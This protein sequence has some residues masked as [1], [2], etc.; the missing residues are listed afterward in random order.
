MLNFERT[1]FLYILLAIPILVLLY[2]SVVYWRRKTLRRFGDI[3]L[4]EQLLPSMS[5][6]KKTL[7]FILLTLAFAF[8]VLGL[9]NFRFGIKKAEV[10]RE[11]SDI[12]IAFDISRSMLAE[13]L[14]PSR[15]ERAKFFASNLIRQID[16]DKVGLI[17]FAGHAFLQ[18]PLTVDNRA[19]IM[20]TS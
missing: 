16:N 15:L 18:S 1:E 10:T 11:S 4:M 6:G 13:D 5:S 3:E 19:V 7:R 12:M 2:Y 17:V 20:Y 9:A 14:R 8:M